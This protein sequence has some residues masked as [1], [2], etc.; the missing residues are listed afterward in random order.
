[1]G[2][3]LSGYR[4]PAG[5]TAFRKERG[6]LVGSPERTADFRQEET[7]KCITKM[8]IRQTDSREPDG[9]FKKAVRPS[10]RTRLVL[11]SLRACVSQT[12]SEMHARLLSQ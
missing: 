2:P 9:G 3:A 6:L 4:V 11:R 5:R 10:S 12:D 1:M 7:K 8:H